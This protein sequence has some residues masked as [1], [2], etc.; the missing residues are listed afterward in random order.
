MDLSKFLALYHGAK[1]V[2][3]DGID[4]ANIGEDTLQSICSEYAHCIADREYLATKVADAKIK[5]IIST[6]TMVG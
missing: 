4:F 1:W 2:D 3:G 5:G 6:N